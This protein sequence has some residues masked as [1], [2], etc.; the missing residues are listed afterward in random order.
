MEATL[1]LDYTNE[2]TRV[3]KEAQA[4]ATATSESQDLYYDDYGNLRFKSMGNHIHKNFF[5]W[6]TP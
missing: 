6:V 4:V 3:I 2:E 5:G 1:L